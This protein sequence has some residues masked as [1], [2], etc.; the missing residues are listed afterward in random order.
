MEVEGFKSTAKPIPLSLSAPQPTPCV[1]KKCSKVASCSVSIHFIQQIL[2]VT[3][4]GQSLWGVKHM[5]WDTAAIKSYLGHQF[6]SFIQQTL[7]NHYVVQAGVK[8]TILLPQP[9]ERWDY[10]CA[11]WH[12]DKRIT[13]NIVHILRWL[14]QWLN[15]PQSWTHH[16]VSA[17]A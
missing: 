10:R 14:S 8:F 11:P 16:P 2:T 9:P 13:S 6:L 17:W 1:S 15:P 3:T 7:I 5:W 4:D 12:P